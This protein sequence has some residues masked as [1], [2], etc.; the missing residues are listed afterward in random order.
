MKLAQSLEYIPGVVRLTGKV[1]YPAGVTLISFLNG[2]H[3]NFL[4]A[5]FLRPKKKSKFNFI[6]LVLLY[7]I[8]FSLQNL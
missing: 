5:F 4:N 1:Q 7:H 6:A 8:I 3:S 2:I